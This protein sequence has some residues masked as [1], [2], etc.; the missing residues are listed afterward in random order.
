MKHKNTTLVYFV[1]TTANYL[2]DKE[3]VSEHWKL[4]LRNL[5][6]E[7]KISEKEKVIFIADYVYSCL[8]LLN[9]LAEELSI[10]QEWQ[11]LQKNNS[12]TAN[13]ILSAKKNRNKEKVNK[14]AEILT[15]AELICF[16]SF[17]VSNNKTEYKEKTNKQII[18]DCIQA[19]DL[20]YK[21]SGQ[22]DILSTELVMLGKLLTK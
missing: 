16:I 13:L 8:A 4:I 5:S 7:T 17:I 14:L 3:L 12:F 15:I 2:K 9:D 22:S 6:K 11:N 20:I 1:E 10:E 18:Q 19:L 21:L